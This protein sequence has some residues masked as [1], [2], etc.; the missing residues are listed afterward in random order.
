M[1]FFNNSSTVPL[2]A[3]FISIKL[4]YVGACIYDIPDGVEPVCTF[5]LTFCLL[6]LLL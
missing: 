6:I 2:T 5:T 4:G 3:V 1:M